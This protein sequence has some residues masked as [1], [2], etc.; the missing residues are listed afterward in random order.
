MAAGLV[1]PDPLTRLRRARNLN[2]KESAYTAKKARLTLSSPPSSPV[3]PGRRGWHRAAEALLH[4][5]DTPARTAA[6]FALGVFFSFSPF[7]GLQI[8]LSMSI[9]F[10]FGLNRLA[11]FI[12]LNANLP[13][14]LVP[15]YTGTT[16][17][18]AWLLGIELPD[19]FGTQIQTLFTS[20][21]FTAA[22]WR[23]AASI[24][25][26]LAVPVLVGPTTGAAIIGV[27]TYP[28]AR[29]WLQRRAERNPA[30]RT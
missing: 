7:I 23:E 24:V 2:H 5:H 19:A 29:T 1:P 9:A 8:L 25:R 14:F 13:W 4:L 30:H 27:L 21:P 22:F 28:V 20:N 17:A 12:G 10:A 16:L 18:A 3:P 11:V 26:P 15:W 6:A